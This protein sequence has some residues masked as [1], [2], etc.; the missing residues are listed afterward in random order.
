MVQF[1]LARF[2]PRE[3]RLPHLGQQ[4][5]QP[6]LPQRHECHRRHT[7]RSEGMLTW[8]IPSVRRKRYFALANPDRAALGQREEHAHR[9]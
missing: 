8:R 9:G 4:L 3:H 1:D 2:A 5:V 6:H 7:S